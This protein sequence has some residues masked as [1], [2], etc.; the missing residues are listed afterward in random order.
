MIVGLTGGI[1]S[2]KSTVANMF[3]ELGVPV[4]NSDVEAKRLMLES[5]EVRNAVVDLFGPEAYQGTTLNRNLIAEKVFNDK[6]LLSQLNAIVHPAV[7]E[8][9]SKWA[10]HQD[11]PYLIQ[12]TALIFENDMTQNYDMILLVTAPKDVRIQRVMQRDGVVAGDVLSR[13][14]NQLPDDIKR[15]RADLV[16]ENLDLNTTSENVVAIHKQLINKAR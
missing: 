9:F 12:E 1:G 7:R 10:K 4:Y 2:G 3:R 11:H 15:D 13:M 8:D 5:A 6:A 14:S 16:I